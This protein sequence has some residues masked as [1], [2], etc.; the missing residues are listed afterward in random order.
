VKKREPSTRD[1]GKN[2][3]C[4]LSDGS[5][6][7]GCEH[8]ESSN[9]SQV[10]HDCKIPVY[11]ECVGFGDRL[12]F[13]GCHNDTKRFSRTA[14]QVRR[15][16]EPVV[17]NGISD[18]SDGLKH[19]GFKPRVDV[20]FSYLRREIRKFRIQSVKLNLF[21]AVFG[22][23]V[24]QSVAGDPEK[25]ELKRGKVLFFRPIPV[26]L[27]VEQKGEDGSQGL[28][29]FFFLF[30]Q[31]VGAPYTVIGELHQPRKTHDHCSMGVSTTENGQ[32]H[33]R[34]GHLRLADEI[35]E[36]GRYVT[37]S[38]KCVVGDSGHRREITP[39]FPFAN[40]VRSRGDADAGG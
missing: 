23:L 10:A 14:A 15:A 24:V 7:V 40:T 35:S 39:Q 38:V 17:L 34:C 21:D 16:A 25:R 32:D 31:Q 19:C 33:V 29:I 27:N 13:R 36:S 20:C 4:E 5:H 3:V 2:S 37:H 28:L 11:P 30:T 26:D 6:R 1:L 22:N 18:L 12:S 9:I 8:H